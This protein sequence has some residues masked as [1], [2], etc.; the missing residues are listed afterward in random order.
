MNALAALAMADCYGV[1]L[2]N[3]KK[4]LQTFKGVERRF[5]YKIKSEVLTLIDDYA[6]HPTEINAIYESIKEMYPKQKNA[7]FFQPH[8]FSRTRDFIDDFATALSR[9][10]ELFLLDIYP[11]RELPIKGVTSSW[12]LEK[13]THKNKKITKRQNLVKDIKNSEATIVAMLG[14]GDIGMMI[15]EVKNELLSVEKV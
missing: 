11:A 12:L 9:F 13:I 3:I 1:P 2:E 7:V 14:A 4:S 5:S 10:D 8:L 15:E 6:H